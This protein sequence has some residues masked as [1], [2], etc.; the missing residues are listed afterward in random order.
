MDVLLPI[1]KSQ[2]I[3]KSL[4]LPLL[5]Y[6]S[7]VRQLFHIT[8]M[9]VGYT[10]L[11]GAFVAG[12]DAGRAYNT[13]PKMGDDWI[14][15]EILEMTPIWKNFFENTAT[16]QFDHRVLAIT[17]LTSILST[18]VYSLKNK[19]N[20][21]N[22][23][24]YATRM[25]IHSVAAVACLQVSLGITTLLTYVPISL[26]VAHQVSNSLCSFII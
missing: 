22:M 25:S 6:S 21:F 17:T 8:T 20:L 23:L 1:S 24:P 26:G 18:Y 5:E 2:N 7:R 14:P 4:S 12:N 9:F 13:F 16:V 15:S 3:A 19:A 11:S 10:A